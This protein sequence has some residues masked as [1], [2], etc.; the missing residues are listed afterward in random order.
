MKKEM[1]RFK[2]EVG[3]EIKK[4]DEKINKIEMA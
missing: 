3:G 4:L 1:E 2:K